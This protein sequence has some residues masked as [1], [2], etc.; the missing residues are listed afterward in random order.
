MKCP[1]CAEEIKDEAVKCHFCGEFLEKTSRKPKKSPAIAATL[2]F[3]FWG[4]GYLYCGRGWGIFVLLPSIFFSLITLGYV[5]NLEYISLSL[6][7]SMFM[8]WHAYKMAE[9]DWI[10]RKKDRPNPHKPLR[11]DVTKQELANINTSMLTERL[12]KCENCTRLIGKLESPFVFRDHVVCYTCY[13]RLSKSNVTYPKTGRVAQDVRR[14]EERI[15][16]TKD[17]AHKK[18]L[19]KELQE[20]LHN[21]KDK[22]HMMTGYIALGVIAIIVILFIGIILET[23]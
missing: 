22:Q 16:S 11:E 6:I 5:Q 3:F 21:W 4:A 17:P 15:A 9:M 1:Y 14:L 7:V 2:N 8:A 19:Q 13:Q 10:K 20:L 18:E 12:E 23:I